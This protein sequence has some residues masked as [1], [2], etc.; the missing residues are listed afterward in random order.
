MEPCPWVNYAWHS[1]ICSGKPI[2]KEESRQNETLQ[3]ENLSEH[4]DT[5]TEVP[6][7][8]D[9]EILPGNVHIYCVPKSQVFR[10]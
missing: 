2:Q 9:K 3:N 7:L 6:T 4:E 1:C 10:L 5:C 8:A